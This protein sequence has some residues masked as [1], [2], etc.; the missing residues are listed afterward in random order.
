M[1]VLKLIVLLT[2]GVA[3]AEGD[4]E[5]V[6]VDENESIE[7]ELSHADTL[8][9]T[10]TIEETVL[11]FDVDGDVVAVKE[12][13]CE[14]LIE[15]LAVGENVVIVLAVTELEIVPV[16][17]PDTVF[18]TEF[19]AVALPEVVA[20]EHDVPVP[21]DENDPV[22]E[23]VTHPDGVG[24]DE[25]VD[26]GELL[27]VLDFLAEYDCELERI[28]VG[29]VDALFVVRE[30]SEEEPDCVETEVNDADEEAEIVEPIDSVAVVDDDA[31]LDPV[32]D[33]L[34]VDDIEAVT[35][36]V[37]VRN[38]DTEISA[39]RDGVALLESEAFDDAIGDVLVV[40]VSVR[41]AVAVND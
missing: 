2:V 24:V 30:L 9:V 17:E 1:R 18:V 13:V 26:D 23:S 38:I 8:G 27:T 22:A 20:V 36:D 16:A 31:E 6:I 4:K 32:D 40:C 29:E 10:V 21:D 28:E 11:S 12:Y 19:D 3:I 34:D 41:D 33:T 14:G 39:V 5:T 25:V 35:V 37:T 7:V 15:I